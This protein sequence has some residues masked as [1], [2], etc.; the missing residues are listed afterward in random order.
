MRRLL[1]VLLRGQPRRW[2]PAAAVVAGTVAFLVSEATWW[3]S[4]LTPVLF[5]VFSVA[6]VGAHPP[7]S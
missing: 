2:A 5:A 7:R 3:G 4:A 1:G 6:L